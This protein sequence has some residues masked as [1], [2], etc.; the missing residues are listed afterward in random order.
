MA[1]IDRKIKRKLEKDSPI[2][3]SEKIVKNAEKLL[4]MTDR[5]LDILK[6]L[7]FNLGDSENTA[8]VKKRVEGMKKRI[9]EDISAIRDTIDKLKPLIAKKKLTKLEIA[10]SVDHTMDLSQR[11]LLL[12]EGLRDVDTFF[13]EMSDIA[14]KGK[15]NG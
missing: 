5:P 8:N 3:H 15:E 13:M 6:E 9:E 1:S 14:K 4:D 10:D 2:K 7:I 11:V 12:E